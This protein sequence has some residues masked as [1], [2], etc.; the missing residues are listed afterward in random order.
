MKFLLVRPPRRDARDAGL[1]VPPLGLAYVASALRESGVHVEILD[2]YALGLTWD[3]FEQALS[4][5]DAE[6]LGLGCRV[7]HIGHAEV[8]CGVAVDEFVV[9]MDRPTAQA[10]E[11]SRIDAAV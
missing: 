10:V 9:N 8:G 5:S 7:P 1:S 6:V 4:K 11:R 3:E 2:A